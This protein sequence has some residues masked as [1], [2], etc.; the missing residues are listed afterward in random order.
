[1]RQD[2][3]SAICNGNHGSSSLLLLKYLPLFTF[4]DNCGFSLYFCQRSENVHV[5]F[6]RELPGSKGRTVKGKWRTAFESLTT[7][8][9]D[10]WDVIFFKLSPLG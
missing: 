10:S 5:A 3:L 4:L 1:M 7:E 9:K 8:S 6:L 2:W